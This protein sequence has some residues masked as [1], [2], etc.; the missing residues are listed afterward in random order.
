MLAAMLRSI[1]PL[2]CLLTL[3]ASWINRRQ[4]DEIEYLKEENRLLKGRVLYQEACIWSRYM[5]RTA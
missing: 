3:L 2:H 5:A 4:L 1:P